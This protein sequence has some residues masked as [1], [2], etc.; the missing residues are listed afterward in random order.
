MDTFIILIALSIII[1]I[2]HFLNIY[3]E[4]TGV[5]SVLILILF[6]A[7]LQLDVQIIGFEILTENTRKPLLEILGV[8]GL[9]LILLEAAL[10]L[11]V[12]K[13][14]IV[15]SLRA[16]FVAFFGLIGSSFLM[17]YLLQSF[18]TELDFL[19][20]LLYAT[21]LSI[22]SSAIIIPSIQGF[23]EAKKSFLIY[24]S[25]FSDVLGLLMF[26]VIITAL[27]TGDAISSSQIIGKLGLSIVFSIVFM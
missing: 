21:P 6:G 9:I 18:L 10:E 11:K 7:I 5:P 14:M 16:F 2:S 3:S 27:A 8:A 20:A 22:I 24:E 17:A 15:S 26:Q 19:N 23:D 13:T 25:T 1:I 12:N 4:N